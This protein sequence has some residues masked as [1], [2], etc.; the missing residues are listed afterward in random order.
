[1]DQPPPGLR[2]SGVFGPDADYESDDN[3]TESFL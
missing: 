1:M 2:Q 3:P